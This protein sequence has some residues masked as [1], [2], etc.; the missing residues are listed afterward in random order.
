[1]QPVRA[2]LCYILLT[3]T[4]SHCTTRKLIN[5]SR[6]KKKKNINNAKKIMITRKKEKKKKKYLF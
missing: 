4:R 1:M 3:Y 2:V 6:S 5:L